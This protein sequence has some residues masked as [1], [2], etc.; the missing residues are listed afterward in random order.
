MSEDL[1]I[2]CYPLHLARDVG[3]STLT[4]LMVLSKRLS[5]TVDFHGKGTVYKE[6]LIGVNSLTTDELFAQH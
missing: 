5:N 6:S 3:L 4:G 1:D 2:E